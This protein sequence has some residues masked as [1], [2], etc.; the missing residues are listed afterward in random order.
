MRTTL[1][2]L[3]AMVL[4]ACITVPADRLSPAFDVCE[5]GAFGCAP[6]EVANADEVCAGG[7]EISS[8]ICAETADDPAA[9]LGS[10]AEL[11]AVGDE[12][13]RCTYPCQTDSQCSAE[14][15]GYGHDLWCDLDAGICGWLK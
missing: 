9:C 5:A 13:G 15:T 8:G 10:D 6:A 1:T 7:A 4:P 11:A 2:L 12:G 3:I 14:R